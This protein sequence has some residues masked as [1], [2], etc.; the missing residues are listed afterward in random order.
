MRASG[1]DRYVAVLVAVALSVAGLVTACGKD[2]GRP[3]SSSTTQVPETNDPLVLLDRY[4]GFLQAQDFAAARQLVVEGS[5]R[6]HWDDF[7]DS[8]A[9]NLRSLREFSFS[10][11]HSTDAEAYGHPLFDV[12]QTTVTLQVRWKRVVSTRNGTVVMYV[13]VGRSTPSSPLRIFSESSGP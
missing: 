5:I 9:H 8:Y 1:T 7:D 4:Y 3:A 6:D 10:E 12:T 11:T 13:T 2:A